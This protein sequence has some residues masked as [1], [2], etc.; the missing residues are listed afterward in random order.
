MHR[1]AAGALAQVSGG[2]AALLFALPALALAGAALVL[3]PWDKEVIYE[4][5]VRD[6]SPTQN[7][8]PIDAAAY[9]RATIHFPAKD[10]TRLEAWFYRPKVRA[11]CRR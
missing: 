5:L 9:T 3:V 6:T 7:S 10:G 2:M 4:P 1:R 11:E 8:G